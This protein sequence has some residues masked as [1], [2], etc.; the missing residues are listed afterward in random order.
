M[1]AAV[2]IP[3]A[4]L[5][6]HLEGTATP[7]L[8]RRLARAQR[9]R[10]ARGAVPARAR[11]A[12]SDFLHFL[13]LRPRG[14]RIRTAQDYRDVTFEY[15]AGCAAGGRGLRR[16]HRVAGPR[17]AGRP[18]R[19]RALRR[20]RPGHRRRPRR[21][22][23][24]ARIIAT[25]LRNCG[26]EGAEEV[27]RR[28]VAAPHPYVVGFNMAGD[29]AGFPPAPFARAFAIAADGGLG[30]TVHAGE[31]AG[32]ESVRGAMALPGVT[33][34]SHGVR[35][36]EDPSLVEELAERGIVLEVCPT[37]ERRAR[38]LSVLR[39]ASATAL[40]AAGV[41]VT[42]GSDDPP[43]FATADRPRVR[44]SRR[45]HGLR[46]RG[47]AWTSPGRRWMRR[48]P[49]TRWK[50]RPPGSTCRLPPR[51]GSATLS[52]ASLFDIALG[53][54][55]SARTGCRGRSLAIGVAGLS[56]TAA[57]A[58]EATTLV[59]SAAGSGSTRR[60][61]RRPGRRSRSASSRTSAVSTTA[62]STRWPT[63]A[64]SD[65][66][67]RARRRGSRADLEVQRRLRPEPVDAGPAEV[68]PR[69][70]RRLPD[71]RRGRHRRQEVP[72]HQ[73]RDHRRRRGRR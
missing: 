52:T 13:G 72:G 38:R 14:Q 57:A 62:R 6:V 45:A 9:H 18:V 17:A 60:R 32:P 40:H 63:R 2:A 51:H 19:R 41:R 30:C 27:A 22:G 37:L 23:I 66:K 20:D 61:S 10:A 7:G 26:V 65:A 47:A 71:G 55:A 50:T 56:L 12:W 15:L 69:H 1:S 21:L 46:R 25:C 53:G 28:V 48:S 31:H 73:V 68:R 24:V 64:W 59:G 35:A 29:E 33:R 3:K 36:I 39:G 34:I 44:R 58:A 5:H 54:A 16:A 67:S 49:T 4:E 42:L 70:R 8:I 43:Y 11:F